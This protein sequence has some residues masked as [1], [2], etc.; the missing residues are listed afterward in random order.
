M[1]TSD[2]NTAEAQRLL[3]FHQPTTH[4]RHLGPLDERNRKAAAS[5]LAEPGA[6]PDRRTAV[7]SGEHVVAL[8]ESTTADRLSWFEILRHLLPEDVRC[9]TLPYRGAP[10]VFDCHVCHQ[11]YER[12]DLTACVTHEAVV[13]SLCLSTDKVGDHVLPAT[14]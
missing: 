10:A 3:R 6:A 8:G 12:P 5:L 11:S 4:V 2:R 1:T 13:C 14:V 9:T 7:R